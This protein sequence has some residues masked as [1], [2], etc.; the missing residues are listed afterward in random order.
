[1]ILTLNATPVNFLPTT[2]C[3]TI[4]RG[5]PS[6]A[7][8]LPR[9]VRTARSKRQVADGSRIGGIFA[10]HIPGLTRA[11]QEIAEVYHLRYTLS[12]GT[13]CQRPIQ[14]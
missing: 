10:D 5:H 13:L 3:T 4:S 8:F 9:I 2:I 7:D 11:I 12:G 14:E 6:L 1:M